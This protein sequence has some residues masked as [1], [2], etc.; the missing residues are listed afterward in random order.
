MNG[1]SLLGKAQ[2]PLDALR[3]KHVLQGC[4]GLDGERFSKREKL[5]VDG[6]AHGPDLQHDADR[7]YSAKARTF[8]GGVSRGISQPAPMM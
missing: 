2:S 5:D 7:E 4:P 1:D 6:I 3:E 8:S